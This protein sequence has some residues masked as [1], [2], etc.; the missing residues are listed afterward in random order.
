MWDWTIWG[1][2]IAA[3]LAGIAALVFLIVRT[4]Q[5][6][7]EVKRSRRDVARRLDEFAAKSEAIAERL[8]TA[9]DTAELQESLGR[10]RVSLAR[11]AV[12]TNALDE[13][14]ENT[15]DRVVAFVPRK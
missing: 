4:L 3:F 13:A 1:A 2:L 15:V 5:S 11:L 12:L 9:G 10:L 14:A 7:R 6:W 8:A